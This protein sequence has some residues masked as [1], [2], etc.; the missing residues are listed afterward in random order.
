MEI[1]KPRT[2][3]L[4]AATAI[5]GAILLMPGTGRAAEKGDVDGDGVVRVADALLVLRYI[6]GVLVFYSPQ[7]ELCDVTGFG[8]G[9]PVPDGSCDILDAVMILY[10]A[11]GQINF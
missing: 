1:A 6:A 8:E 7:R 3:K 10:K 4:A 2:L 9:P 11:Y 5:L